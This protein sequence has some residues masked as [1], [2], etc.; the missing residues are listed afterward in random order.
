MGPRGKAL[1]AVIA[2]A[3]PEWQSDGC[4]VVLPW[5]LSSQSPEPAVSSGRKGALESGVNLPASG[6]AEENG[7]V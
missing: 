1:P 2:E 4:G 7:S 6:R 3:F 5:R